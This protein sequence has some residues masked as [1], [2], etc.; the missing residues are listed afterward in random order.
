[1]KKRLFATLMVIF[2]IVATVNAQQF[3]RRGPMNPPK[4]V[5]LFIGDGMGLNQV[6]MAEAYLSAQKGEVANEALSFT[7]FPVMGMSTTYSANSYITCSSAAGTALSTGVKT[8]NGMLG[9][10]PQGNKLESISYKIHNKGIPVGIVSSVTI[11]HATPAAFYANSTSRNNYYEIAVQL[12][13]SGF[14]FF[15]G[16]GFA[17]PTG[18]DKDQKDIYEVLEEGGYKVARG[19]KEYSAIR[20]QGKIAM[21]QDEGKEADLPYAIDRK[22]DDLCLAQVVAAAIDH[23]YGTKG[24]FIMA[25]GGK[26]DWAGHGNDGKTNILEVLDFATSVQVAYKFYEKYPNETLIIVTADH[27]TG[28]MMLG[29]EKGYVLD[30]KLLDHQNASMAVS[31]DK[32]KEEFSI[33]NKKANIGWTTTSHTGVAVPVYAIGAGSRLFSGRM[34]NTDIPKKILSVMGITE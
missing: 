2:A 8:N 28:G 17:Q 12:P 16:G 24:F 26:I 22:G 10:D 29:R 27:E 9:V 15:G 13:Q 18:P 34:D 5:F 1:M 4:F 25:E 30:L 20:G 31:D 3:N 19:I 14:E 32:T 11:D 21:F 6:S 7:K 33:L 23:L